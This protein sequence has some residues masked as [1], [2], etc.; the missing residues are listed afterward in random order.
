[1]L[2]R[3]FVAASF[4]ALVFFAA[5]TSLVSIIEIPIAYLMDEWEM[6]RKRAVYTQAGLLAIIAI[7]ATMSL[8][9]VD[10]LTNFTS[11]GGAVKSFF[12]VISDV[13]YENNITVCRIYCVPFLC[14]SLENVRDFQRNW[15][16]E[17]L[18]SLDQ[19]WSSTLTLSLRHGHSR[20]SFSSICK[21]CGD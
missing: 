21:Y 14:L 10:F 7:P 6:T 3:A 20:Y 17:I 16:L 18:R 8:G 13:F 1:M 9:M 12:D 5:L 2:G 19:G 4:F 11:Y 15:R